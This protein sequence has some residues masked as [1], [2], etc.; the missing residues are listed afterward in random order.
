MIWSRKR[1]ARRKEIHRN[2]MDRSRAA[3]AS[4]AGG[5]SGAGGSASHVPPLSLWVAVLFFAAAVAILMMRE[6]VVPYRPGQWT[7]SDIVSRVTFTWNDK[8]RLLQKQQ[9]ARAMEP[10][11][12]TPGPEA[13]EMWKKL[14]ERLLKLPQ[15]VAKLKD[16]ELPPSLADVVNSGDG[17]VRLEWAPEVVDAAF[18]AGWMLDPNGSVAPVAEYEAVVL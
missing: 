13:G 11:V 2:R 16:D 15:D 3:A 10:K 14:E 9:L 4:A 17:R 7:S 12:Y 8:S 18:E 6:D 5:G 1:G